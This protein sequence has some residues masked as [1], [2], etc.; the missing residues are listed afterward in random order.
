ME[1]GGGGGG[2]AGGCFDSPS[3]PHPH[4]RLL[5]QR[6]REGRMHRHGAREWGKEDGNQQRVETTRRDKRREEE[7]GNDT[8][9][10]EKREKRNQ[11]ELKG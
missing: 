5:P 10:K 11:S 8:C 2:G 9:A 1:W 4:N 3:T 7:E 6:S